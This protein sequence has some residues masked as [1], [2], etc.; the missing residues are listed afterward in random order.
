MRQQRADPLGGPGANRRHV[1]V[2]QRLESDGALAAC[3]LAAQA[4]RMVG[5]AHRQD[6]GPR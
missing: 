5:A 6:R 1:D 4:E 3:V 2:A